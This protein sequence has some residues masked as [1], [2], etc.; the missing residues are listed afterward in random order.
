MT[1]REVTRSN[2]HTATETD[3]NASSS[4]ECPTVLL[5]DKPASRDGFA[6]SENECG[7]FERVADAIARLVETEP[8]GRMIGLEG[9]WGAGKSTVV[10]LVADRF[11][12]REKFHAVVAFDAWAHEGDPLRRTFLE[13]VVA[14]MRTANW[15]DKQK[16]DDRV[17]QLANR[18][19][20]TKTQTRRKPTGL[21]SCV[22]LSLFAVPFGQALLS[23]AFA[24]GLTIG[25]GSISWHF[26]LGSVLVLAPLL[27][28]A[29]FYLTHLFRKYALKKRDRVFDLSIGQ[30][31]STEEAVTEASEALNPT[32]IEFED[33]F[34]ELLDESLNG[35]DRR[36][37][38]LVL[39]NL[40]RVDPPSALQLWSTL[41]A[42]LQGQ[43]KQRPWFERVWIL[44]PYDPVGLRLLWDN[45]GGS[46]V[47]SDPSDIAHAPKADHA[48]QDGRALSST[49]HSI[50]HTGEA[51][52]SFIDKS[53]QI[54]FYVPPPVIS[55]WRK[56]FFEQM[57]MALPKHE[58]D[59]QNEVFRV[60][61]NFGANSTKP[62][63]PRQIKLFIN[64][65]GSIHRQWQ[66]DFPLSHQAYFALVRRGDISLTERLLKGYQPSVA[67]TALLGK[68][69][70]E[71]LAGLA[72][73]VRGNTGLQL[74]LEEP[75]RSALSG[76]KPDELKIL[77]GTHGAGF[78]IVL[79]G[80][81]NRSFGEGARPELIAKAA[82]CLEKSDVLTKS[83]AP[84][85]GV[86][87]VKRSLCQTAR[88]VTD[89]SPGDQ[90]T[91]RGIATLIRFASDR[92]FSTHILQHI[93]DALA[94]P[95][96]TDPIAVEKLIEDVI[97]VRQAVQLLGHDADFKNVITLPLNA[98]QWVAAC[99]VLDSEDGY[100]E[101]ARGIRPRADFAEISNLFVEAISG[102]KVTD[103]V[104]RA[105]RVTHH[106]PGRDTW[107]G[108]VN[109]AV[110]RLNAGKNVDQK[111]ARELFDLLCEFRRL[112][113]DEAGLGIKQLDGGGHT[114]H[115]L[116][117]AE[118]PDSVALLMYCYLRECSPKDTPP[119][120]GSSRPGHDVLV[121]R[122]QSGNA[123][124]VD[125]FLDHLRAENQLSLLFSIAD[126]SEE[127]FPFLVDCLRTVADG[128][129]PD[130]LYSPD[131]I[132]DRRR[133][134][135]G[136]LKG[137]FEKLIGDVDRRNNVIA[138]LL[139]QAKP[140]DAADCAIYEAFLA[141]PAD[142]LEFKSWC[143]DG[144]QR[145]TE[146]D[147]SA[148]LQ[149]DFAA[150]KLLLR[151]HELKA[152]INLSTAYQDALCNH[153]TRVLNSEVVPS[154]E[155]RARWRDSLIPLGESLRR[156]LIHHLLAE[157]V[158]KEGIVPPA[159]FQMYGEEIQDI[160]EIVST[161]K[162]VINM[163]TPFVRERDVAGLSWLIAVFD[164]SRDLLA[165]FDS[166][167]HGNAIHEF[168]EK[169]KEELN[170]SAQDDAQNLITQ[171]T[172]ILEI[173]QSSESAN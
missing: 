153:A 43:C 164:R 149:G 110:E 27:V 61:E 163:F 123:E 157:M 14:G 140:F 8:G 109:A 77:E 124:L 139:G 121:A 75:I 133:E 166:K 29:L 101:F 59:D 95:P 156:T 171:L 46:C 104:R 47:D 42:F 12:R 33:C 162:I 79:E 86:G 15:C 52:E 66:H 103:D 28:V 85:S 132:L 38:L 45:R 169:L 154:D 19:K 20:T 112:G 152:E 90:L 40:D 6:T 143:G 39:D 16:W 13:A 22:A 151:L 117:R 134:L 2:D 93:S 144:L 48:L 97:E 21:A 141:D 81:V 170:T 30:S 70:R 88:S 106:M 73:N 50:T 55:D 98:E 126:R 129:D 26:V 142:N 150:S 41:Q 34:E 65:V 159:F 131:V 67:A 115:H 92:S 37:L 3:A 25:K 69:L 18:K 68:E 148:Q 63:T 167:R 89:W 160:D 51:S 60:F 53:F 173:D 172:T 146:P 76:C 17:D 145:L 57:K 120:I 9:H 122:L 116:A 56:Y 32:S 113:I 74:L 82:S 135:F 80:V 72:F 23:A 58:E 36:R 114:L 11:R 102:R 118:D 137:I 78:W 99:K 96:T 87:F 1:H 4:P 158:Q 119:E 7:P 105:M 161:D 49:Q 138:R 111:E 100:R 83:T 24:K 130:S 94:E 54:R 31:T 91:I 107:Q 84:S 125:R 136:K 5:R 108:V 71:S 64:Q 128:S 62:P 10:Q 127:H 155:L 168:K 44:V 165:K 147:W 35:N